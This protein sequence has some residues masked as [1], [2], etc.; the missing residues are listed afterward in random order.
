MN[1]SLLQ[2]ADCTNGCRVRYSG[3]RCRLLTG[4]AAV[5]LGVC[6]HRTRAP[7][8]PGRPPRVRWAVVDA[9]SAS[10]RTT[11][12]IADRAGLD[13]DHA[14]KALRRLLA[15]GA[16]VRRPP[17]QIGQCARWRLP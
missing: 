11:R 14:A 12:S 3:I 2:C 17:L 7:R 13:V 15:A 10:L 6:P 4:R 9:L 16:V 8:A 5:R 1:C